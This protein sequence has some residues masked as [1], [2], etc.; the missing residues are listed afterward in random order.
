[1]FEKEKFEENEQQRNRNSS[2]EEIF[3]VGEY[4]ELGSSK[5]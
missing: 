1:V 5:E 4:L 2:F 3:G